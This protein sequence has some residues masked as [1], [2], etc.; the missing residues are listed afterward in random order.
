MTVPE[1]WLAIRVRV[2]DPL[3]RELAAEALIAAGGRGV[4]EEDEGVVTYL[5]E[6][7]DPVAVVEGL[8]RELGTG[9][10]AEPDVDHWW[11]PQEDWAEVW[12]RGLEPR[13]VTDRILIAPSWAE[14]EPESH[15]VLVIVDPGL[16][17]GTAEHPT[18]R[19]CLRLMDPVLEAGQSLLDVGAGTAILSMAAAR[20]G[21]GS[22][23]AVEVDPMACEAAREN[24]ELNRVHDRV[25]ILEAA[26]TPELLATWGPA[27]GVV[28]NIESGVLKPLMEGL[29][30]SVARGGWLILSG[31]LQTER[32]EMVESARGVHLSLEAEDREGEWWSG[33]FRLSP[34]P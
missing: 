2:A 21:A 7:T 13:A 23:L 32:D 5:P 1:R 10:T 28:A 9:L 24:V 4:V 3:A 18:T 6:P 30:A 33:R 27:Q 17:F 29:A 16:A 20:L 25:R 8:Q 12:K 19:G 34:S 14:V 31:I 15:Q 26:A 22:V 11:Q